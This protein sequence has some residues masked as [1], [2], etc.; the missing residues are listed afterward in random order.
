MA[1]DK[2][3]NVFI[4]FEEIGG[5]LTKIASE[6]KSQGFD[7]YCLLLGKYKFGTDVVL[8]QKKCIF[9]LYS[10][11]FQKYAE[12]K[13]LLMRGLYAVLCGFCSVLSLIYA[14]VKCFRW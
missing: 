3:K 1:R 4:G 14:L 5:N 6:F 13:N 9:S 8:E 7:C 2:R 10:F 11:F 12:Q